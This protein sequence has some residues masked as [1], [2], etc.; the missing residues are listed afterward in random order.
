MNRIQ[1][2]E[3][4]VLGKV[5]GRLTVIRVVSNIKPR[6]FHCECKCS[7]GNE[8][9]PRVDGIIRGTTKSCGC[10][11]KEKA[12]LV[13]AS[14][15]THGMTHK[16][17]WTIWSSMK[18]RCSNPK[19]IGFHLYGGRGIFVC[20][21]WKNSF[22]DFLSD[23]GKRPDGF[24]IERMN[25]DGPYSPENCYWADRFTQAKNKR[26]QKKWSPKRREAYEKRFH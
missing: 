7:C 25:N 6:R 3:D 24:S 21:R 8:C 1:K 19:N 13:G 12:K 10:I 16:G 5:F 22:S 9:T 23:M 15:K 18:Q 26:H 2:L 20:D 14:K 4:R 11:Q 17:E